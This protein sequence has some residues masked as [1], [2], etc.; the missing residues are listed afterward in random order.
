MGSFVQG[1]AATTGGL[2]GLATGAGQQGLAA[3]LP[4]QASLIPGINTANAN[5]QSNIANQG[6][7]AQALMT[8]MGG[9]GPNLAGSLLSNA[10]GQNVANTAANIAS[11]RGTS[12]NV[13]LGARNAATAGADIQQK[14][15][16]QAAAIRQQ[17]ELNAQQGLT[18][19]Y[20]Q[21]GQ[22]AAQNLATEQGALTAQNQGV[23][24]TN[25]I[26][27]KIGSANAANKQ[28]QT[29]AI[30]GGA[31]QGMSGGGGSSPTSGATDLSGGGGGFAGGDV[32]DLAGAVAAEG[33][34]ITKDGAKAPSDPYT[35]YTKEA[36]KSAQKDLSEIP[37]FSQNLPDHLQSIASIYHPQMTSSSGSVPQLSST[38]GFAKGGKVNALVSPG[39]RIVQPSTAKAVANGKVD[40]MKTEKVPG[41]PNVPGAKDSYAN[42]TV[43]KKLAVGSIVIPRHITMGKNPSQDAARFVQAIIEKQ[44]KKKKK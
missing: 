37:Q 10:T 1:A 33:G 22:E 36:S 39:E 5:V 44:G 32:S 19:V 27:A 20:G 13:G 38:A 4:G 30:A 3:A 6:T 8:Q 31:Q 23:I 43:P 26:N 15:V 7:F 11:Q 18:N 12:S 29:Q 14:S 28:A 25:A 16:G 35:D 34:E 41:K 40:A 42:D 17:Q 2:L 21:I 24:N 9:G